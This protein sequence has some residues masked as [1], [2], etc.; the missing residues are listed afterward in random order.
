MFSIQVDAIC[1]ILNSINI[2]TITIRFGEAWA[3][4]KR[5]MVS[6]P[7]CA[8]V[9]KQNTP[10]AGVSSLPSAIYYYK[11]KKQTAS[12]GSVWRN[13]MK[14]K[15]KIAVECRFMHKRYDLGNR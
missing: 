8:E 2:A 13:W 7:I 14:D 6:V 3:T 5:A 12:T 15:Y 11:K 9:S 10:N 1:H 4:C